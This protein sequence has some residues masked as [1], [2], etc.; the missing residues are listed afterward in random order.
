MRTK[1]HYYLRRI[2]WYK[3]QPDA[4]L[5]MYSGKSM[6]RYLSKKEHKMKKTYLGLNITRDGSIPVN[7]MPLIYGYIE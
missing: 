3:D 1:L 5:K 4:R 2:V 7:F 6:E